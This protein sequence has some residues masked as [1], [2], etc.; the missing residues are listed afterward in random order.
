M[1]SEK[2]WLAVEGLGVLGVQLGLER[3]SDSIPAEA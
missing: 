3:V 2:E 1:S